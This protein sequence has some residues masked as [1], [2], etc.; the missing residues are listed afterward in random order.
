MVFSITYGTTLYL[1]LWY[2]QLGISLITFCILFSL[3]LASTRQSLILL[4]PTMSLWDSY[5]VRRGVWSPT[6]FLILPFGYPS[7]KKSPCPPIFNKNFYAVYQALYTRKATRCMISCNSK[8]GLIPL[9][10][11]FSWKSL[12][13]PLFS[14]DYTWS[15]KPLRC[16]KELMQGRPLYFWSPLLGIPP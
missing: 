3:T 5:T 10:C 7:L 15:I 6:L 14:S 1:D 13:I 16:K 8:R 11:I 4:R 2:G 9:F 12:D